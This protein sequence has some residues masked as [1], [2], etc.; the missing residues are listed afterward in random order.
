MN[1]SLIVP[2]VDDAKVVSVFYQAVR[3]E[4]SLQAHSVEIVLINDGSTDRRANW[5]R[6]YLITRCRGI[7][8]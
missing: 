7:R 5:I 3:Q 1:L 8:R 6:F 4:P 2:V